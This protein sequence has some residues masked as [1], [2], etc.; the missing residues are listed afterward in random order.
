M[1][2]PNS[3]IGV[4]GSGQLGRM[5]AVEA[6]KMGYRVHTFSPETDTP[7]GQVADF[8]LEADYEDLAKVREFAG[9]V[10][11][12]TFEFEN[13]PSETIAAA[14]QLVEVFPSGEVLHTTQNRLREKTFLRKNGFPHAAFQHVVTLEDLRAAVA[15]IGV[16]C[17]LKTAG[18][19]YDGKGQ[20]KIESAADIEAAF[21]ALNQSE[22]VLEKFIRFEREV[23]VVCA[24]DRRGNFAHYGI[25]EN[26]HARHIL[27]I[28]SAPALVSKKV[29]AEAIEIARAVA[30]KFD[31]VGTLC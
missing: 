28:S 29:F 3:T 27:D 5:F 31:Y 25:I 14:S 17:V 20:T 19:G 22:T 2:L 30:E 18:F 26:E 12:V 11:V 16:P 15:E 9:N 13:V 24:R 7:T 21:A 23:S 8:E 10:D 6:R 4:F 1:I